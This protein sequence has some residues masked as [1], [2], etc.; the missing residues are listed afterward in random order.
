MHQAEIQEI[1]I[2]ASLKCIFSPNHLA[3]FMAIYYTFLR[4]KTKK[5]HKCGK[6]GY[7]NEKSHKSNITQKV[8]SQ[9]DWLSTN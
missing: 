7:K 1:T 6:I 5:Y 9:F 8:F 4:N 3:G 2:I